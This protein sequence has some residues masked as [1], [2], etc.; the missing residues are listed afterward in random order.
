VAVTAEMEIARSQ[1]LI[2]TPAVRMVSVTSCIVCAHVCLGQSPSNK[3]D[4]MNSIP[5]PQV[6]ASSNKQD[7]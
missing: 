2:F 3:Q 1:S 4:L 6:Q 7:F 5:E